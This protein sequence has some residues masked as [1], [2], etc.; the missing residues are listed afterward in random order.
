MPRKYTYQE[1][2]DY[3]ESFDGFELI[4]KDYKNN[5]T[6]LEIKTPNNGIVYVSFSMFK[7]GYR[8]PKQTDILEIRQI[9]D[10][11]D[12]TLLDMEVKH[13]HEKYHYI[14]NTHPEIVQ[15][16][17]LSNAKKGHL[18]KECKKVKLRTS[19]SLSQEFVFNRFL[20]KGLIPEPNEKYVNARTSIAVRCVYHG[21]KVLK[22]SYSN[23]SKDSGCRYCF[24]ESNKGE[25]NCN[26]K[27][28]ITS[29]AKYLRSY[30]IKWIRDS[31]EKSGYVCVISGKTENLEV[32]HLTSFSKI[33][34][35]SLTKLSID[36][37]PTISE[38]SEDELT[39]LKN[40]V[41]NFHNDNLGV[42]LHHNIHKLFHK[43]YGFENTPSQFNEFREDVINGKY[44]IYEERSV[45]A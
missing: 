4:S 35:D 28:G 14:C 21:D 26:W 37:K 43:I 45:S 30:T 13:S 17:L 8:I 23:L 44:S 41:V 9:F 12:C 24:Y 38:Y 5:S 33:I 20:E 27:G 34:S 16:V 40:D 19:Q 25:N 7:K 1:I 36:L 32:H 31:I 11:H 18:C 39:L 15:M 29:L 6:K 2:K 22:V 10:K 3:I 42:V